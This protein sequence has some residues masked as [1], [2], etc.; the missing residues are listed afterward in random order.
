MTLNYNGL[1]IPE[2][3]TYMGGL[4]G[5]GSPQQLGNQFA[6]DNMANENRNKERMLQEFKA[7]HG[8]EGAGMMSG[9]VI[10]VPAVPKPGGKPA[11][12]GLE[13]LLSAIFSGGGGDDAL[14][15]L[16]GVQAGGGASIGDMSIQ[17]GDN[18]KAYGSLLGAMS[19]NKATEA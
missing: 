18:Q 17:G 3:T 14:P 16:G 8:G 19:Q 7:M 4:G 9:G 12:N 13:G 1:P 15:G 10:G 2:T 11:G 5:G 6:Y